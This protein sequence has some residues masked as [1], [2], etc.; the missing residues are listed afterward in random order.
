MQEFPITIIIQCQSVYLIT[1]LIRANEFGILENMHCMTALEK[2]KKIIPV[3]SST[4]WIL[5]LS[6]YVGKLIKKK[7]K[8]KDLI[9]SLKNGNDIDIGIATTTATGLVE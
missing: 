3:Q 2:L 9:I 8:K 6:D 4:I 1:G 5:A 7:G